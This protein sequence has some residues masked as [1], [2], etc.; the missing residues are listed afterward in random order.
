MRGGY[1]FS[2]S[3]HLALLVLVIF[4]MPNWWKALPPER[5]I[6]VELINSEEIEG[7]DENHFPVLWRADGY[8]TPALD[9]YLSS[10]PEA[11]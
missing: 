11:P 2:G 4:G 8:R 9:I 3:L 1:I 5:I 10:A 7:M 6:T